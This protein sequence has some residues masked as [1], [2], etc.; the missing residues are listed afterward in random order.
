[1]SGEKDPRTIA[2]ALYAQAI[3]GLDDAVE[4]F[5][6]TDENDRKRARVA[7]QGIGS[8]CDVVKSAANA[9]RVSLGGGER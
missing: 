9:L 4:F 6:A 8:M 1:M 3:S 7:L 2:A 5:E